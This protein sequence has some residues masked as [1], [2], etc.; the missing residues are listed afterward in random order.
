MAGGAPAAAAS[1]A[2]VFAVVWGARTRLERPDQIKRFVLKGHVEGVGH[3]HRGRVY[4]GG[5]GMGVCVMVVG[6]GDPQ[7]G[8]RERYTGGGVWGHV[9]WWW[10]RGDPLR[11]R[12][13]VGVLCN[14]VGDRGQ[15]AMAKGGERCRESGGAR[16]GARGMV[17]GGSKFHG[18][19]GRRARLRRRRARGPRRA[20]SSGSQGHAIDPPPFPRRQRPSG[21]RTRLEAEAVRH[22]RL[23]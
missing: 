10:G 4:R 9:C 18:G 15:S 2:A 22:P 7:R 1:A 14:S 12:T 11:G 23:C 16:A 13:R 5:R 21:P 8:R 3:L 6:R 20:G 17:Q 19:Q